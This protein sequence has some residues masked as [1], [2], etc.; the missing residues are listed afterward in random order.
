[1]SGSVT[2]EDRKRR[3]RAIVDPVSASL[4]EID[5]EHYMIHL[6]K[7]FFC[8][9]WT[10]IPNGGVYNVLL[11]TPNSDEDMHFFYELN[12]EG[13]MEYDIF[14]GTTTT[15]D[16]TPIPSFNRKRSSS[17]TPTM[18]IYHTPTITDD[19]TP[20]GPSRVGTRTIGGDSRT[21]EEIELASNTK[22][23]FRATNR[24]TGATNLFNFLFNWYEH[25]K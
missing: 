4:V 5:W 12:N 2:I 15:N 22:Y 3:A 23:L 7:S 10:N 11:V 6:G 8:R 24:I 25:K 18:N 19:G 1:M 13:E 16:G 17:N 20:I 14:E 21:I 9:N